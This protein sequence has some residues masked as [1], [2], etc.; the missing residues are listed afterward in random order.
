[1]VYEETKRLLD[2][3]Y[4]VWV[5]LMIRKQIFQPVRLHVPNNNN[6]VGRSTNHDS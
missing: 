3:R 5:M 6:Y 4:L 1:M 2:L